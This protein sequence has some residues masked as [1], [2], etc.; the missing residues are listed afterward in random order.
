MKKVV[1]LGC[2]NS[3]ANTF[4][5]FIR[6]MDKYKDVE[7]LGVYSHEREASERLNAEFGVKIMENY[8]EYVGQVDGVIITARHGDN[9]L[10]YA[11]P[12][13]RKGVTMFID[14]PI[15]ISEE[16]AIEFIREYENNT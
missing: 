9:H 15:T 3:H 10:K 12:Y 2:E 14:K 1:I 11:K 8:D 16:E 6:D 5:K 4:L 7:V 13:I